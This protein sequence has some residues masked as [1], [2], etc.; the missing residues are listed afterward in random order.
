MV[1]TKET[2]FPAVIGSASEFLILHAF[3]SISSLSFIAGHISVK[4][5]KRRPE[6]TASNSSSDFNANSLFYSV[7]GCL[8]RSVHGRNT[9]SLV[10]IL[11]LETTFC[12]VVHL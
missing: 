12:A 7:Q 5:L 9:K 8:R 6:P 3:Q 1:A 4:A 11:H 10:L 2:F